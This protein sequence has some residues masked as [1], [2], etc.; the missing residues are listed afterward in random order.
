MVSITYRTD[1][2]DWGAGK[3]SALSAPE[4]D[5]NFHALRCAIE[6]LETSLP[7]AGR[8]I[9]SLAVQAAS[10]VVTYTDGSGTTLSLPPPDLVPR[11]IWAAGTAYARGDLVSRLGSGLLCLASHVAAPSWWTDQRAGRWATLAGGSL[12][13]SPTSHPIATET[14]LAWEVPAGLSLATGQ[15]LRIASAG[16]PGC[17]ME[18]LVTDYAPTAGTWFLVIQIDSAGGSGLIADP[19]IAPAS[20]ATGPTGDAAGAWA[21]VV[22]VS[23]THVATVGDLGCLLQATTGSRIEL[24]GDGFASGDALWVEA[25]LGGSVTLSATDGTIEPPYVELVLSSERAWIVHQGAG[26]W[27]IASRTALPGTPPSLRPWRGRWPVSGDLT[28]TT[29]HLGFLIVANTPDSTLTLPDYAAPIPEGLGVWIAAGSDH[30]SSCT[31]VAPSGWDNTGTTDLRLTGQIAHLVSL[32]YGAWMVASLRRLN[33]PG[34]PPL[35]WQSAEAVASATSRTVAWSDSGRRF[36]L[37]DGAT[38]TLPAVTAFPDGGWLWVEGLGSTATLVATLADGRSG[39]A[40]GGRRLALVADHAAGAWVPALD[41]PR[42]PPDLPTLETSGLAGPADQPL[43]DPVVSLATGDTYSD[44]A[45]T[46]AITTALAAHSRGIAT[47]A[48]R[49]NALRDHLA[50]AGLIAP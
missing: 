26:V 48:A 12:T 4:V 14:T 39:Q 38:L 20:A 9:A 19:R 1:D 46:Q 7:T 32:G 27:R 37:E 11:G 30:R 43:T 35:A 29:D 33:S 50:G 5:R 25:P 31:V 18:G 42:Q 10:L 17:W 2:P 44:A 41:H 3:G 22:A 28:L 49:L 23:G 47:L 21:A 24:G 40:V 6:T 36:R 13:D 34:D 15:R 16:D 8:G 45:V